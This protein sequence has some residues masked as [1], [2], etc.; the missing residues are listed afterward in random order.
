MPLLALA[1]GARAQGK[2]EIP[3]K[4]YAV[5][6][7]DNAFTVEMPGIPDHRVINDVS[8]RSTAFALHSYSLESGGFSYVVQTALYPADVD[9]TQPRR[10]LQAALDGRA[11]QL[12]SRKWDRTEWREVH[13]GASVESIGTVQAGSMLRLLSLLKERRFVSLAFLGPNVDGAE[14]NRF[15]NSLKLK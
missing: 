8:A 1:G 14:A 9:V 6:V 2:L 15:F 7:E 13:A 11:S 10:L 12:A 3:A 4:W 5:R